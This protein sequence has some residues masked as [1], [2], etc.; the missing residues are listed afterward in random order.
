MTKYFAL[1]ELVEIL[2]VITLIMI[3]RPRDWPVFFEV[4]EEMIMNP[5][6]DQYFPH[7]AFFNL[8]R[9]QEI[10]LPKL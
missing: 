4:P 8:E 10:I 3:W 5:R 1:K 7:A 6:I 9:R 2:I